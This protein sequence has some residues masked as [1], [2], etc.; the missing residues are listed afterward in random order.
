MRWLRVLMMRFRSM[1][2]KQHLDAELDAELRFHVEREIEK[3]IAR[4]MTPEQARY[5][6]IRAFG[7]ITRRTEDCRDARRINWIEDVF[8]DLRYAARALRK[9]LVFTAVAVLTLGLGIGANTAI[10]SVV[11]AVLLRPLPYRDSG[12]IAVLWTT[13]TGPDRNFDGAISYRDFEQI[14][15]QNRA[16]SGLTVFYI[17]GWSVVTLTG[18]EEPEKVQ[19]A[20]VSAN[21]FSLLGILPVL[22]RAIHAD[23]LARGER[24]V[25]ISYALWQQ[26]FGGSPNALERSLEIGGQRWRVVGVMPPEFRFPFPKAQF[27]APLTTHPDWIS[28]EEP[29]PLSKPR[30]MAVGRLKSGVL[31]ARAQAEADTIAS[32]LRR[33]EPNTDKGLGMRIISL[34]EH[35]TEGVRRALLLLLGAVVLVL[36]VAC[37]NLANLS[38]ARGA[39][40]GHEFAVRASLGAAR[41]R[42]V[43][44]LL[45]ESCLL[46]LFSGVLGLGIAAASL[47]AILALAPADLPRLDTITLNGS[48]FAFTFALS[49][50][51]GLLFGILPAWKSASANPGH[52][53]QEGGR[54]LSEGRSSRRLHGFLVTAE[55]A[56]AMVLATGAGLLI[57]SF[58]AVIETDPGFR[59]RHVLT[60]NMEFPS[61][62]PQARIM[63]FYHEA[64]DRVRA[65]PGVTAAGTSSHLFFLNESRTHA[66]RQVEGRA[67]EP[68]S[69]WTPL[70][71][72][73]IS[74]DYFRAMGIPLRAGRFFND[75]DGPNAQPVVIVNE[76][77]AQRYWPGEDPVG[78]RLK[79]FDPRGKNDD[80][81]TV[82]GVVADMRSHGIERAPISQIY[83]P[84]A[85][86]L[87]ETTP[88]LV[89]RTA[90]DP[91][92]LVAN[93]REALRSI[94]K[95]VILSGVSTMEQQ[96]GE[97]T[98]RRRFETWLLGVFSGLAL[99][100][101]AIGIY[102]V[103][104]YAVA[105]R[106]QE[107]GIR[108]ALGASAE[109]VVRLVLAQGMQFAIAGIGLGL[110][111]SLWLARAMA[112]ML[113]GITPADPV[114]LGSAAILLLSISLLAAYLPARRASRIDPISAL[115]YE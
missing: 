3:E 14:Q 89:V 30:W 66:L 24:V 62:V 29:D 22:G 27:W 91:L 39:A 97:Q 103:M 104:Y 11:D 93:L 74:G 106:T 25:V 69:R 83:E 73:Q 19:G 99:A 36:L 95:T 16:F 57:R 45:T 26:R 32:R 8:R 47:R 81:L 49:L 12:R 37:V 61:E 2:K 84:Q 6:A 31:F 1:L 55:F 9:N 43:R 107:L 7:G 10:F 71:W 18:G 115:R 87:T 28:P 53:L 68:P 56:L 72:T 108:L 111:S 75:R 50:A 114:A 100:L 13:H 58:V 80:W 5:S 4:G 54:S 40:R 90:G 46:A 82:A 21:F 41:D 101:A 42:L 112:G 38:L 51:A 113:Y 33:A 15:K 17:P 64:L 67:P 86:R 44:Q 109:G 78:R 96:L 20:H 88:N 94:D 35:M 65:L 105:R 23:D 77:L 52:A 59:P 98:A 85:Q 63:A 76:T 34:R 110:F 70:V 48:V 60:V 102:G 92:A 79:G